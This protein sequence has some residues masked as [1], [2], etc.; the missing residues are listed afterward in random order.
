MTKPKSTKMHE[1]DDRAGGQPTRASRG[2][3]P[4]LA[5][6]YDDRAGDLGLHGSHYD[7][8]TSGG[9]AVREVSKRGLDAARRGR[10]IEGHL[11]T[12]TEAQ[13][14]ILHATHAPTPRVLRSWRVVP[15]ADHFRRNPASAQYET[16]PQS[17]VWA[18][19]RA[20][21]PVVALLHPSEVR[22]V[23]AA[24]ATKGLSEAKEAARVKV[25]AWVVEAE[26][27]IVEAVTAY[28]SARQK[29]ARV[30]KAARTVRRE[31][32]A[33]RLLSGAA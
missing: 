9:E 29:A 16:I 25:M 22:A 30:E 26:Q 10:Q 11:S 23:L 13:R 1:I 3:E 6:Y 21:A 28:R 12:L 18:P 5:W 17:S 8:R 31:E 24:I 4:D 32:R 33:R 7:P 27:A 14:K 19:L 2:W 15:T 20:H